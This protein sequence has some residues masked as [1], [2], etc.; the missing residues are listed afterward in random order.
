MVLLVRSVHTSSLCPYLRLSAPSAPPHN[1]S[2]D[3]REHTAELASWALSDAVSVRIDSTHARTH[4]QATT[5]TT[6]SLDTFFDEHQNQEHLHAHDSL[7]SSHPEVIHEASEPSSPES[8]PSS[9]PSP[10]ASTLSELIRNSQPTEE[11]SGGIDATSDFD[12]RVIHA[13]TVGNGIISQPHERTALL[14]NK[15]RAG[16]EY[17][18]SIHQL[19]D[20]ENGMIK[21]AGHKGAIRKLLMLPEVHGCGIIRVIVNP[22]SW[23]IRSVWREGIIQPAS[24]APAVAI[25]LLLNILDSLSYGMLP[26]HGCMYDVRS[27]SLGLILFP[28]SEGVFSNLGPDGISMFYVSCIISQLVYSCGG[29][30]FKGGVGSEMVRCFLRMSA[31]FTHL[32]FRS[33]SFLSFIA[34]L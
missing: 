15:G 8:R 29:S 7:E 32:Y 28:L 2:Q 16:L 14:S 20:V 10:G 18:S 24:Y 1:A 22:K 19:R 34:W 26:L 12:G 31:R 23:N 3:V 11:E 25:G 33:K 4:G 21:N 13:V 17:L 6:N 5:I 9:G 27:L 30:R